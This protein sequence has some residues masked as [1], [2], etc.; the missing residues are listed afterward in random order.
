MN[1]VIVESPTKARTL[2]RYLGDGYK[3]M[4]SMGHIRD[5]PHSELGVDVAHNFK[6]SYQLVAGRELVLKEL[7]RESKKS[8]TVF[9][10]TDPDREGEAIAYHV[11]EVLGD[12]RKYLRITFHEITKEAIKQALANP[13]KINLQ[14]VDAQQARRVLDRLVG[15]NLSPLLW[16]KVRKGLSAGRVQ[17]VAVRLIVDKEKE[18]EAFK[19][20]EFWRLGAR[21]RKITG[22]GEFVAELVMIQGKKA[23]VSHKKQA[24]KIVTELKKAGYQVSQVIQKQTHQ[25][26]PP[27]FITSTL[28]RAGA[29][30][31]GWSSKKTMREAQRLYESGYITYHRTDSVSLAAKAVVTARAYIAQKYGKKYLPEKA[32]AYRTSS[33]LAQEAHEAIRPTRLERDH[34]KIQK[35]TG[36]HGLKLYEL[37]RRRFLACQMAARVVDKTKVTIVADKYTL[38]ANGEVERFDGWKRLYKKQAEQEGALQLPQLQDGEKLQLIKVESEQKFTQPP[39]RFSES[40]LIKTLEKLGIGRPSTYAPTIST[41]Q[42][43]KYVEKREGFFCPTTLGKAVT[44]FLQKYFREIMD[45]DFTAGMEDDLDKIAAGKR[46]W[47]PVIKQ[48]YQPFEKILN[49]VKEKAKRVKIE[50]Q[51]TGKKCPVCGQGEEVIRLG[52]FGKF[53]SCSRFPQCKYTANYLEET[54]QSCPE[55]KKGRVILRTTRKGRQFYGCSRFPQCQWASWHKPTCPPKSPAANTTK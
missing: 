17:S 18:I 12:H 9:L 25:S 33:K 55:C 11:R 51:K 4:A 30:L 15:Y 39:A 49:Q 53:L 48:F 38:E 26:P 28:Q 36:G 47:V 5:L 2:S 41:I 23:K 13:G 34:L 7:V 24:E 16:K 52:R 3:V 35:R 37:V 21:L 6:P 45:Y 32:R 14:L 42:L 1:L 44:E 19:P 50:T 27:P 43:R 29:N 22:K 46:E 54:G 10:A 8:K 31:F 40:T 20:E